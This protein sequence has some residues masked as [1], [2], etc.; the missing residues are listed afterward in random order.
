MRKNHCVEVRNRQTV[1]YIQAPELAAAKHD[2]E[3]GQ[4]DA[5]RSVPRAGISKAAMRAVIG[6]LCLV[7]AL[8]VARVPVECVPGG[9]PDQNRSSP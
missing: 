2:P 7:D 3:I 5:G 9:G 6:L 1:A 4:A 8:G